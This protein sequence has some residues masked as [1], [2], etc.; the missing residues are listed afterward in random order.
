MRAP[1]PL[2]SLFHGST[3]PAEPRGRRRHR[4]DEDALQRAVVQWLTLAKPRC[5]WFHVPNGGARDAITGA[6][7]KAMGVKAGVPDLVFIWK[8][9]AGFVELKRPEDRCLLSELS[10][11]EGRLSPSQRAFKDECDGLGVPYVVATS[12][13][14]AIATVRS[15]GLL[16]S[17]PGVVRRGGR[18]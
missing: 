16:G 3:M 8:G 14:E 7:L 11:P 6:K 17:D 18:N 2:A 9:G 12:V 10:R 13:D 1:H 15:W 4:L 5:L